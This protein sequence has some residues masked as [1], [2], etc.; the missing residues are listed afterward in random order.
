MK[1]QIR[2]KGSKML[3]AVLMLM[4]V[5]SSS[6]AV[7][8]AKVSCEE[9]N[10]F[11]LQS[12]PR[13]N[14]IDRHQLSSTHGQ[15]VDY[16]LNLD[17]DGDDISE[18]VEKSCPGSTETPGDPCVLSIKLSSSGETLVFEAWGFQLFRYK[19][20][21]FVA[22]NADETRTK[23]TIYRVNKSAVELVCSKL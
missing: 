12:A 13:P 2:W 14:A 22:A 11:R 6:G 8:G 20:Q 3:L 7:A 1:N 10:K 9:L 23:T 15:G 21:I 17:I 4:G 18:F 19:G 5:L 16:Y